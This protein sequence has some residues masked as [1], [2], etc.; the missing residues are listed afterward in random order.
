MYCSDFSVGCQ[1]T[2]RGGEGQTV[3]SPLQM[4]KQRLLQLNKC[5][6]STD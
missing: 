4:F 1:S 2:A 3:T 6:K 5:L